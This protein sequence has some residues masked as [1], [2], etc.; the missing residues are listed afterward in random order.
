MKAFAV[1]EKEIAIGINWELIIWRW[2]TFSANSCDA[3]I[4]DGERLFAIKL[5]LHVLNSRLPW[6]RI[7]RIAIV[8]DWGWAQNWAQFCSAK[9]SG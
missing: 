5:I 9:M 8:F 6:R 2:I 4:C 1:H 3:Q 7:P